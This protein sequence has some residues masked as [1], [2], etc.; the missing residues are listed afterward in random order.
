VKI[1]AKEKGE[2][3]GSVVNFVKKKFK[4]P[5]NVWKVLVPLQYAKH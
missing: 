2:L 5:S 1:W 4:V 3:E